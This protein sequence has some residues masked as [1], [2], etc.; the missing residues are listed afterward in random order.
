MTKNVLYKESFRT[1]VLEG[2]ANNTYIGIGNPNSKIL[3]VG[4]EGSELNKQEDEISFAKDWLPKIENNEIS[5][6]RFKK[7]D[8]VKGYSGEGHTWNKYQKLHDYIFTEDLDNRE[9]NE[10]NFEEKIFTTEM[11]INRSK[12][13]NDAPKD[14]MQERKDT[15]FRSEFI[16]QFPVI[17]LACGDYIKNN[18]KVREIDDI[19]GVEFDREYKTAQSFWT[20]YNPDKTKLVIHTRQLSIAVSEELLK[21]MAKVIIEH[22]SKI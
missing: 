6:R 21:D 17:I 9:K 18:E 2:I 4:K 8:L 3:I 13:A 11:N 20:H 12:R 16:Q 14:G 10:I 19:F 7:A 15:F 1:L 22:L 5:F